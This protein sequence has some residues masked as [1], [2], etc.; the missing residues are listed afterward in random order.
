M[1]MRGALFRVLRHGQDAVELQVGSERSE[2]ERV[3]AQCE[4]KAEEHTVLQ[5]PECAHGEAGSGLSAIM[6]VVS[7]PFVYMRESPEALSC[8]CA[9]H[10]TS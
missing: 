3:R 8:V 5:L 1:P 4:V 9:R 7:E 10:H 6:E 2:K